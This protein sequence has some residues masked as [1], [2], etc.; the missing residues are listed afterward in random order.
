VQQYENFYPATYLFLSST[1]NMPPKQT[2]IKERIA[3]ASQAIDDDPTLK[4]T[5]AALWFGAPYQRLLAC[6]KGR[7]ASNTRG[8]HNKRLDAPWDDALKEY[9]IVL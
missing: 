2:D 6:Q 5:K 7:L 4:A 8:G 1:T 9:I 3:K